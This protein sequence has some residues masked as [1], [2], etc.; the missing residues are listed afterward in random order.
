MDNTFSHISPKFPMSGLLFGNRIEPELEEMCYMLNY[1]SAEQKRK[2]VK[3]GTYHKKKAVAGLFD[4]GHSTD[5]PHPLFVAFSLQK[6][7]EKSQCIIKKDINTNCV[8][9]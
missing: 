6:G 3:K 8:I 5:L 1:H 4:C 9:F 7:K 2:E